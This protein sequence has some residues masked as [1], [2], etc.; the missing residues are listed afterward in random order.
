[1]RQQ[2]GKSAD[3]F[4]YGMQKGKDQVHCQFTLSRICEIDTKCL[5]FKL[6]KKFR[7]HDI[8]W[9]VWIISKC[10]SAWKSI[11]IEN[12][13]KYSSNGAFYHQY[14]NYE[15]DVAQFIGQRHAML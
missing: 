15:I 2:L 12:H 4:N 9:F 3:Q 5:D 13:R 8:F 10:H 6:Q 14:V 7:R 11:Q 1:M